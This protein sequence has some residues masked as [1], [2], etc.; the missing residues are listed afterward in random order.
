MQHHSRVCFKSTWVFEWV[1]KL[2]VGENYTRCFRN[3]LPNH[4]IIGDR[5]DF[6][7]GDGYG[8]NTLSV[9]YVKSVCNRVRYHRR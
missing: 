5:F 3:R 6:I 1:G 2:G 9:A 4:G 8:T 7:R